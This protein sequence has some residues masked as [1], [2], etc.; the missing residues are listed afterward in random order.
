MHRLLH[1][2]IGPD[3]EQLSLELMVAATWGGPVGQGNAAAFGA[4]EY[5]T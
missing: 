2:P 5:V 3:R 4:M 1:I